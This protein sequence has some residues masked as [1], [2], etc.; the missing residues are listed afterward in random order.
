VIYIDIKLQLSLFC[1]I[2]AM[3]WKVPIW[4]GS[5]NKDYIKTAIDLVIV[6]WVAAVL[7]RVPKRHGQ[8]VFKKDTNPQNLHCS[9]VYEQESA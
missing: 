7:I 2:C 9:S 4:G 3:F 8:R 5:Q 6:I 1:Y